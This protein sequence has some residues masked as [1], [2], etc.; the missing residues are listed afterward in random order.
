MSELANFPMLSQLTTI[1]GDGRPSENQQFDCV[2]TSILAGVMWLLGIKA[3]NAE[4][5]P[6]SMKDL[7]YGEGW[8]NQ[9]TSAS[10]FVTWCAKRGIK[11]YPVECPYIATAVTRAHAYIEMNCPVVFTEQDD[12]APA[13]YRDAWS[14]VC[15]WYKEDANS[16]TCLDPYIAQPLTYSNADWRGRLRSPVLWILERLHPQEN[17]MPLLTKDSPEITRYYQP[18][19][20][21][22]LQ[23][24]GTNF[25]MGAGVA[26]FYLK[27]GGVAIFRLIKTGEMPATGHPGVV[28]VVTEGCIIVYDPKDKN[29]NRAIDNP[30][31]NEACYLM[32]TD[33][34]AGQRVI[35]DS[36]VKPLQGEIA[37]L[38]AQLNAQPSTQLQAE[39]AQVKSRLAHIEELAKL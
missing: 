12:Y 23:L 6:D 17:D 25:V 33:S 30:P 28:C 36:L 8:F 9:G 18:T 22:G 19:S 7:A 39:L 34:G 26:A 20:N 27:Y 10:A 37:T 2:P 1:T 31:T 4:Y 32:H 15:V 21:G 29:G 11:L 24:K 5:N 14:H 16:L 38:K 13:Q 3:M 35:A